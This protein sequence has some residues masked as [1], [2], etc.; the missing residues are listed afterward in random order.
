M[1]LIFDLGGGDQ[2]E[3]VQTGIYL[4]LYTVLSSLPLLFDTFLASLPSSVGIMFVYIPLGSL[5]L[6]FL[7]GNVVLVRAVFRICMV[8]LSFWL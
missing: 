2:P 1:L 3:R 6:F 7:C 5:C 4:L 8:F